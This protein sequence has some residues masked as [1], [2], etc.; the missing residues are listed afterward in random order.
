MSEPFDHDAA[1]EAL[2]QDIQALRAA[3]DD[4]RRR[5]ATLRTDLPRPSDPIA[6]RRFAIAAYWTAPEVP[7]EILAELATGLSGGKAIYKFTREMTARDSDVPCMLCGALLV[8]QSREQLQRLR[9]AGTGRCAECAPPRVKPLASLR[10]AP[11]GNPPLEPFER[12]ILQLHADRDQSAT[13]QI[14]WLWGAHSVD[15]TPDQVRL[16]LQDPDLGAA[17][18]SGVFRDDYL[19]WLES[20]GG[21]QCGSA[22][23]SGRRCLR[24]VYGASHEEPAE[25]VQRRARGDYCHIHGG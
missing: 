9:E 8:V 19:A 12:E 4:L 18:A 23:Q 10:E 15:L 22:T 21:V 5:K 2:A 6:A 14:E 17:A 24:S 11:R 25:W 20:E 1:L 16:Y 13:M 7:T 3:E